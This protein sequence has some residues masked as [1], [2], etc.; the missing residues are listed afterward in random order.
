MLMDT[1]ITLMCSKLLCSKLAGTVLMSI[2]MQ[3]CKFMGVEQLPIASGCSHNQE[4]K[5]V[6]FELAP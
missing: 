5:P 2:L 3:A 6:L 1:L 4:K